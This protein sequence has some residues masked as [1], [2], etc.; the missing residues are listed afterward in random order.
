MR[1]RARIKRLERAMKSEAGQILVIS[2]I[3]RRGMFQG[4]GAFEGQTFTAEMLM[5]WPAP[6]IISDADACAA[7]EKKAANGQIA[8]DTEIFDL[9]GH[10]IS[11]EISRS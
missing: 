9:D 6:L 8:H 7:Y 4:G 3:D 10:V 1:N 11:R 2:G 5:N